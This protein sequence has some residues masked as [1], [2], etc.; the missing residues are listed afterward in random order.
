MNH[1][2][3]PTIDKTKKKNWRGKLKYKP[4]NFIDYE[5]QASDS[6]EDML[7]Q[8]EKEFGRPKDEVR[9]LIESF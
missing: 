3:S 9:R 7:G 1:R 4:R 8:I 6:R 2:Y 5:F